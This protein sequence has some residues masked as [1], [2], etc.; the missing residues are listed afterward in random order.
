MTKLQKNRTKSSLFVWILLMLV[1]LV[2]W[3]V[4]DASEGSGRPVNGLVTGFQS[5]KGGGGLL[6]IALPDG[7]V[8]RKAT[9]HSRNIGTV[10]SCT[11]YTK[12]ISG[13][14]TYQC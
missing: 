9:D 1:L 3:S 10:V 2:A 7:T 5:G 4:I 14:A 13:V 6:V 8:V 12:R 11:R